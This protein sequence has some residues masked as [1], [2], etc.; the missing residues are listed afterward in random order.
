MLW[1]YIYEDRSKPW[2]QFFSTII[3]I[4]IKMKFLNNNIEITKVDD[5]ILNPSCSKRQRKLSNIKTSQKRKRLTLK[6]IRLDVFKRNVINV[7]NW[8]IYIC[9]YIYIYNNNIIII[10]IIYNNN[11]YIIYIYIYIFLYIYIKLFNIYV[12]QFF[13]D[14]HDFWKQKSRLVNV[15]TRLLV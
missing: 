15:L 13:Y 14:L 6:Y 10:I 11:I 7:L 4:W 1:R 12:S 9:Q 2:L 3:V 5:R 8:Q